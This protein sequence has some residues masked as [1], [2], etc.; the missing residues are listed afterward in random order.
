MIKLLLSRGE[1]SSILGVRGETIQSIRT[2]NDVKLHLDK[3]NSTQRILSMK[4]YIGNLKEAV[5]HILEILEDRGSKLGNKSIK[6]IMPDD[7][8]KRLVST[9]ASFLQEISKKTGARISVEPLCLPCSNE[10]IVRLMEGR[11]NVEECVMMLYERLGGNSESNTKA[12]VP[13]KLP[14]VSSQQEV[15][16]FSFNSDVLGLGLKI[17]ALARK[18]GTKVCGEG[19]GTLTIEGPEPGH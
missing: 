10:R 4:G 12:Y 15:V 13:P 8:C 16:K 18:L 11:G 19:S 5:K 1:A 14:T 6:L 3:D 7:K 2:Q 17:R 9:N